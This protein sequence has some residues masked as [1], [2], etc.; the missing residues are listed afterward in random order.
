MKP[1]L[2]RD[3]AALPGK[4]SQQVMEKIAT[5]AQDPLPDGKLKKRIKHVSGKICRIRSGSY[6]ILYTFDAQSVNVLTVR[7]RD[8]STYDDGVDCDDEL[9]LD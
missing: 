4:V 9:D 6:R 5:L 8:E 1:E 2:L 7:K 3:I